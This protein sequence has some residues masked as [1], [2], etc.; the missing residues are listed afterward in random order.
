MIEQTQWKWFGMAGHF[1][2]SN[3]CR[4]HLCTR[5]GDVLVSTV[6]DYRPRHKWKGDRPGDR[7]EIG[8]GRMFETYVFQIMEGK[9]CACGCGCGIPKFNLSEIESKGCN[10]QPTANQN[11]LTMCIKYA[12][13]E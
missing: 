13:S 5:V 1:I 6:G 7:T 4:F 9:G 8:I 2:E 10:E 3:D 12:E 11:H